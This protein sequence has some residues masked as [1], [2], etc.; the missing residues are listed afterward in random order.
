MVRGEFGEKPAGGGCPHH[1]IAPADVARCRPVAVAPGVADPP[2]GG[3]VG[4]RA[5]RSC[6]TPDS[7]CPARANQRSPDRE[8]AL[9]WRPGPLRAPP[10][11][12]DHAVPPGAATRSDVLR[13]GRRRCRASRVLPLMR[14]AAHG[15]DRGA[16][17]RPRH[18]PCAG[19]PV[20]AVNAHPPALAAGRTAQAG[21]SG[22]AGG[23]P[24]GGQSQHTS[25]LP[26]A[27]RRV[28]SRFFPQTRQQ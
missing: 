20:G 5:L 23:A 8:G 18:P 9:R 14:R 22:A 25:A 15:P 12:A 28:S 21:D 16:S 2:K 26:G 24:V 7:P 13:P 17:G 19:A 4:P 11:R 6:T 10:T 3:C 27:G 1:Q